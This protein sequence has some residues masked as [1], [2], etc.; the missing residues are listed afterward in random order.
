MKKII[1][2][3]LTLT[4]VLNVD[5]AA[6]EKWKL[7]GQIRQRFEM[8]DKDFDS[9]TN[10]NNF[11]LLRS[12]LGI[13]FAPEEDV[14]AFFQVQDSRTFG[15]E[16]STLG[17][18]S[19]DNIDL[20]Q[21]YIKIKNLFDLPVD[22]K[23]GRME[24]NFGPQRLVGAVGWHNIGR[25]FDGV[26]FNLRGKDYSV[27]FFNFDEVEQ[28]EVGNTGDQNV[29]GAYGDFKLAN[30]HKTQAFLI[31]Q[32]RNPTESLSRY[33]LG[34][35]ANG[36]FGN[37]RHETEFA[38]QGGKLTSGGTE[39]D[40]RALMAALNLG[41]TSGNMTIT[42][43]ADY[44]SGDSDP[45][46]DKF[47]VFDTMYATN[48]KYYGHMDYFLNIPVHTFGLG[49]LDTHAK[50]SVISRAKTT[51]RAAFH[52]F[53]AN[54]DDTIPGGSGARDFGSEIDIS[55][56]HK[57]TGNVSFVVGGSVFFPGK[58]FKERGREDT[59]TWIYVMSTVNL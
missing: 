17:D 11:N 39:L 21:G 7:S 37:L 59:S 48:H 49:L 1:F 27:D 50:L 4:F 25:S 33:T 52:L 18:G 40:V 3:V 53:K 43:G 44:L 19:A 23:A 26:I 16:T 29:L 8:D 35:Y 6:Q 24:V 5:L 12:R 36:K 20:H 56:S 58:I 15:E 54:Q 51:A 28:L 47:K 34:F 9:E 38:Y 42:L 22:L 14:T 55:V 46:D 13:T 10:S 57:Y 41:Y 45:G 31:W 2:I 30:S 32:K